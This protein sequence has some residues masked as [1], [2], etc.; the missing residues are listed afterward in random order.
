M[1][2]AKKSYTAAPQVP[3]GQSERLAMI[4]EVLAG[5]RSV[6]EA[7]RTLGMSRNH[8][9][10][11]LHRGLGALV[12]S[13]TP[14][15]AGRPA[16][17]QQVNALE[18][19][20]DRLKREN[21]RLQA[22]VEMTDRLLNAASGLLQ[23]RIRPSRVGRTRRKTAAADDD[24]AESEAGRQLG[25]IDRMRR[26]GIS[27]RFA[28]AIAGV[29]PSTVRRWRWRKRHCCQRLRRST[30]S[31]PAELQR[32][33]AGIVRE[34][35]GQ[36]GAASLA[37]S[38]AGLSRRQA[39]RVKSRTLTDMERERKAALTRVHITVPGIVRGMDGLFIH[40]RQGNAHALV[41]A[42]ASIGYRTTVAV[43]R[44][45]D[46]QL[47]TRALQRDIEANGAPL[48]YRFDR[49][50]AHDAHAVEDVLQR[51][52]VLVLHGPPYYP[53]FYGQLER[54][55]REHRAWIADDLQEL[56]V[57][58]VEA[59]M[60]QMLAALNG[61][62]RRRSL[63]WATASEVWQSRPRL[64]LDRSKL[65]DEVNERAARIGRHLQLRGNPADLAQRLAIEQALE[66]RGY[67]R[68]TVGG[69]C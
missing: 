3:A 26:A 11:L 28:A 16:K 4:L 6:S 1:S 5:S 39:A 45:Y 22:Q 19:E 31:V 61:L 42:D 7:A 56:S 50:M 2:K 12:Q 54:R 9:Q 27:A 18:A 37:R 51:H 15:T 65:R 29:H 49:A 10:T 25:D 36:V 64:D 48:V 53:Q 62:W 52:E 23:G 47:V 13:I 8:F 33:A 55:N 21:L 58:E 32:C 17:P 60:L 41:A 57:D 63:C 40:T 69:W 66:Q 43:D 46:A 34:L 30:S 14:H 38:V 67:L 35:R 68:Q 44:R 24:K 59:R 20:N